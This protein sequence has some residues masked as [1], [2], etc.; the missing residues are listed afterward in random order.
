MSGTDG[1][2]RVARVNKMVEVL[3]SWSGYWGRGEAEG[4]KPIST[5]ML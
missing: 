3:T 5:C 4:S 1:G 2:A